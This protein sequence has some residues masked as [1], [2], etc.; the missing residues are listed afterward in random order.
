MQLTEK[1]HNVRTSGNVTINKF[2]ITPSAKAFKIL[3]SGLYSDKI[4]A[5]VRELSTNA[6]DSHVAANNKDKPFDVFLPDSNNNEFSIRDYGVGLTKEQVEEIYTTYFMSDK[7]DS[8]EYVGCLGLGSKSPFAY[9]DNF[10]VISY[11]DGVQYT[12]TAFIDETGNPSLALLNEV[13]TNEPNGLKISLVVNQYDCSRF[14]SAAKKVYRWF[15]VKPNFL[16]KNVGLIIDKVEKIPNLPCGNDW[17]FTSTLNECTLIMGNVGYNINKLP[18]NVF[19][20]NQAAILRSNIC[21]FFDIG[22]LDIEASREGISFDNRTIGHIKIKINSIIKQVQKM[23]DDIVKNSKN[24]FEA[25][26]TVSAAKNHLPTIFNNIPAYF[27]GVQIPTSNFVVP[28]PKNSASFVEQT[29]IHRYYMPSWSEKM[30]DDGCYSALPINVPQSQVY[31]D[32]LS[33]GGKIRI[34]NV[35]LANRGQYIY[36]IEPDVNKTVYN[37]FVNDLLGVGDNFFTK[38]SELPKPVYAKRAKRASGDKSDILVFDYVSD[39][40]ELCWKEFEDDMVENNDGEIIYVPISNFTARFNPSDYKDTNK[41]MTVA[42][43]A[44]Y[45]E[46]YDLL[47]GEKITLYGVKTGKIDKVLKDGNFVHL[48]TFL[49]NNVQELDRV[50]DKRYG[51]ALLHNDRY[52]IGQFQDLMDEIKQR[53]KSSKNLENLKIELDNLD[54]KYDNGNTEFNRYNSL[55]YLLNKSVVQSTKNATKIDREIVSIVNKIN[56]VL[57][58][59][60]LRGLSSYDTTTISET[61]DYVIS[62]N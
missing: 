35:C 19:D 40:K 21:I 23:L 3:S 61:V 25:A 13:E 39:T 43:I 29:H 31:V 47:Y 17:F 60:V 56:N 10:T 36:V 54:K 41:K 15:N 28:N 1:T 48:M 2:K 50:I 7:T 6:Y 51:H 42:D 52:T 18:D 22:E 62:L 26:K 38:T 16:N 14:A 44:Y 32:D 11:K 24:M 57:T 20:N 53:K 12:Y 8:N 58:P 27:N 9:A 45:L 59:L 5:I 55:F 33:R 49:E 34:R 46:S 30:R 37:E 4:L